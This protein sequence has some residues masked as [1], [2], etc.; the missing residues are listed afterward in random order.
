MPIIKNT[1]AEY[2]AS[3][4]IGKSSLFNMSKSPEYFKWRLDNPEE[5][6]QALIFGSAFHKAVLE[7]DEFDSEFVVYPN[8]DRRTKEGKSIYKQFLAV[9]DG[10]DMI[11]DDEWA[12]ICAMREKVLQNPYAVA[13]LKGEIETSYYWTDQITGELCKCRPDITRRFQSTNIVVDLK[14]C[15]HAD[16]ESFMRDCIKYGYDLQSAMY[17]EGVDI[18]TGIP[19]TFVFI[20][21]EK[22]EPYSV[23]VLQAD[24]LFIKRGYD[25]FREYLGLYAE[26][27]K[28]NSWYGYNGFSG[29]INT[30]SL[31]RWLSKDYE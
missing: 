16:T 19:H 12:Q 24:D 25:L 3:E 9:A 20:A 8:C 15:L 18:I 27:K 23:N 2:H 7:P 4:G 6:K 26:C 14:S 13:L 30:L 31:P 10:R 17:K 29:Y 21:V 11:T 22:A 5:D 28:T 1:N